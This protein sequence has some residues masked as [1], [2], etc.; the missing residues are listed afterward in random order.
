M[1]EDVTQEIFPGELQMKTNTC[2][3]E[4]MSLPNLQFSRGKYF[5]YFK[6]EFIYILHK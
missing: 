1:Y 6:Y 2:K 4:C 5:V 3:W